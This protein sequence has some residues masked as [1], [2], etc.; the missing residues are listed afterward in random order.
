MALLSTPA[1]ALGTPAAEFRL[2]N[3]DG[4]TCSL[5][6]IR[7]EKATLV[8]FIC[9]HCPYVKAIIS[10][11]AVQCAELARHGVGVVAVCSNDAENYPE[12]SF[13]KMQEFAKAHA[14]GFPYL[15]DDS[16]ETARAYGAVCTP[17]FFGYDASARLQWRGRI[18]DCVLDA[19]TA[20]TKT[21]LLDAMLEIAGGHTLSAPQI[22]SMGC[23]IKW[24]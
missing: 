19:P 12:D 11:F 5:A 8:A 24:K 9:N 1:V 20:Q 10:R 21:E 16:Q 4:T 22:P 18:D 13:E 15:C 23:S 17:D 3:V 6:D 14:F 7:G 2:K